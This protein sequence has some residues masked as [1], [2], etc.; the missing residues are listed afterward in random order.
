VGHC[1]LHVAIA[2]YGCCNS[3]MYFGD[4]DASG[5]AYGKA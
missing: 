2:T 4:R 5:A 1:G 3:N